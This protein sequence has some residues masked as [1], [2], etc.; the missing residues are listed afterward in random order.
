ML[1]CYGCLGSFP[2]N[3]SSVR[4][5]FAAVYYNHKEKGGLKRNGNRGQLVKTFNRK[6]LHIQNK[7]KPKQITSEI[8]P[9]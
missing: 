1:S 4:R 3:L 7:K 9:A 6:N 2:C 8:T 5:S